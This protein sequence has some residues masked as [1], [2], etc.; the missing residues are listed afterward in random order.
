MTTTTTTTTTLMHLSHTIWW[1][2]FHEW[3]VGTRTNKHIFYFIFASM[4]FKEGHMHQEAK[5]SKP[6]KWPWVLEVLKGQ[7]NTEHLSRQVYIP[8]NKAS[9]FEHLFSWKYPTYCLNGCERVW[10]HN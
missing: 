4:A 8:E 10:E 6:I 5:I 3:Q 7:W 2:V 1:S 9:A